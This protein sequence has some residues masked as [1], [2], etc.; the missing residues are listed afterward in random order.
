[1]IYSIWSIFVVLRLC[2][3]VVVTVT[4]KGNIRKYINV[5]YSYYI[6]LPLIHSLL[7]LS[8]VSAQ[9]CHGTIANGGTRPL[10]FSHSFPQV[11]AEAFVPLCRVQSPPQKLL[12]LLHYAAPMWCG[13]C[14][15]KK[16]NA[17]WWGFRVNVVIAMPS[18]WFGH[19]ASQYQ[20]VQPNWVITYVFNLNLSTAIRCNPSCFDGFFP[21]IYN[22]LYHV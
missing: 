6:L 9:H 10:E 14:G 12:P 1:M 15:T 22:H 17:E 5:Y 2:C 21:P 16:E 13:P 4:R 8:S 19:I 11:F 20:W 3:P 18:F 7:N